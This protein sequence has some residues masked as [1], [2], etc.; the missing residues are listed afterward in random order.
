MGV[1]LPGLAPRE[2]DALFERLRSTPG[3][4]FNARYADGFSAS[5]EQTVAAALTETSRNTVERRIV[6]T[7]AQRH[8]EPLRMDPSRL[9]VRA[10]GPLPVF[11]DGR[12]IDVTAWGSARPRE[13][14]VYLLMHPEGR[15]KKQGGLGF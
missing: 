7:P 13:L 14:L 3:L 5:T 2:R 11:V 4:D 1:G 15:K 8:V 9:R 12:V 10:L 6:A